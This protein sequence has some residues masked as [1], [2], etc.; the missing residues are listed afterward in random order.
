[1]SFL[2]DLRDWGTVTSQ[3][4]IETVLF[5]RKAVAAGTG[6][7]DKVTGDSSELKK[8]LPYA[9]IGLALIVALLFFK[10]KN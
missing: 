9:L 10:R 2:T 3:K 6:V 4:L 8:W 5:G 7:P 1:M